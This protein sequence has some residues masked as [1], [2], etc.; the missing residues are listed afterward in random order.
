MN[1]LQRQRQLSLRR[2]DTTA[3]VRMDST[4]R[5]AIEQCYNLL[6]DTLQKHDLSNCPA[7]IYNMD[8]SGMPLDP[9]PP[10]VVAENGQKKVHY[11]V[12]GKKDQI[13]L[14]DCVN[15]IR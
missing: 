6:E 5:E 1:F 15:A 9:R 3:H 13:T 7:Q 4:N 8:E 12:S 10:N 2:G 14:L 11:R